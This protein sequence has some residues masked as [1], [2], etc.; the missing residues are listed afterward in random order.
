MKTYAFSAHEENSYENARLYCEVGESEKG[1]AEAR[2]QQYLIPELVKRIPHHFV[3][4]KLMRGP[5]IAQYERRL[6]E[7]HA[8]GTYL[9]RHCRPASANCRLMG[10][11]PTQGRATSRPFQYRC[12]RLHRQP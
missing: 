5:M 9:S 10:D 6:E 7:Q 4:V 2:E 3:Y 12:R 11:S 1:I 8:A